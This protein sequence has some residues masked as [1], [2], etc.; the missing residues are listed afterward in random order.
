MP[1]FPSTCDSCGADIKMVYTRNGWLP[2]EAYQ[3]GVKHSCVSDHRR[4][5]S[6][7]VSGRDRLSLF[8]TIEL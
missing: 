6:R 5:D 3:Y 1:A 4:V 8:C 7:K 2:F